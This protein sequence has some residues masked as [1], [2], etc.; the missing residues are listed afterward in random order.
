MSQGARLLQMRPL[1]IV[2]GQQVGRHV[3]GRRQEAAPT[4]QGGMRLWFA[5]ETANLVQGIL[6]T[7]EVPRQRASGR[8]GAPHAA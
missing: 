6:E 5:F 3:E 1:R 4:I 8:C 2:A 7:A